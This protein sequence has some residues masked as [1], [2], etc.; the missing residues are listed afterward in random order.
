MPWSTAMASVC[1]VVPHRQDIH[2]Y[3]GAV[4]IYVSPGSFSSFCID[5]AADAL[6]YQYHILHNNTYI[7]NT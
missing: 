5:F 7:L 2:L 4:D 6:P 3:P 1:A